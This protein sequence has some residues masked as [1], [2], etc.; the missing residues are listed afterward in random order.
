M[1]DG[2]G[3]GAAM[4]AGQITGLR[5]FPDGQ[6]RSFVE[7][8]PAAGGNAVHRLHGASVQSRRIL[9]EQMSKEGNRDA[10]L[11]KA[12]CEPRRL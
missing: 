8:Q 2:L 10:D 3:G 11:K 5:D 6:K 7:I 1:G 9:P 4:L 12:G